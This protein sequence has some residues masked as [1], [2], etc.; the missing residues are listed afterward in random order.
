MNKIITINQMVSICL[1]YTPLF[2]SFQEKIK[3]VT[4]IILLVEVMFLNNRPQ[5]CNN[6]DTHGLRHFYLNSPDLFVKE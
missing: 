1:Y 2:F 5:C 6:L 4:K 3:K